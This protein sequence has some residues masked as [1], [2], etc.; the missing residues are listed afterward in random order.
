[1]NWREHGPPH[2]HVRYGDVRASVT[3]HGLRSA[4][5]NLPP[6]VRREVA[7][8][9]AAHAAELTANWNLARRSLPLHRIS[10]NR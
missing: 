2:F 10:P 4:G 3:I 8:W 1:M 7:A 5:G 9:A 6:R